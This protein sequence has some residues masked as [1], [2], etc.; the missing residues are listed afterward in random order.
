MNRPGR[1][2]VTGA[3]QGWLFFYAPVCC[4]ALGGIYFDDGFLPQ[5]EE[6]AFDFDAWSCAYVELSG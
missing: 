4:F 6:R 3:A 2:V 1:R 5:R